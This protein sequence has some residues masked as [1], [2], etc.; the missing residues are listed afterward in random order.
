M[1]PPNYFRFVRVDETG[2]DGEAYDGYTLHE[3]ES[4]QTFTGWGITNYSATGFSSQEDINFESGPIAFEITSVYPNPFNPISNIEFSKS[5]SCLEYV[6]QHECFTNY[7]IH[8][9]L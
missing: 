5:C 7:I 3:D 4:F 8:V 1:T 2:A 9:K 6:I